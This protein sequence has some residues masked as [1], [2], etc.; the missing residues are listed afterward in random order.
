MRVCPP[1]PQRPHPA[2]YEEMTRYH[3]DD[4]IRFLRTIRPDN[5]NEY[6][7]QMQRF[8]VGED[9]PVFD[10]MY[11]FCQLSSGGSIG[12]TNESCTLT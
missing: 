8:N 11:E 12:T 3:S 2:V 10:G 4:Y 1:R 5:I 6:T 7:K 9:C